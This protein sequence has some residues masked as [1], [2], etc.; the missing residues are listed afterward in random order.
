MPER[1]IDFA[2]LA[3]QALPVHGTQ[4]IQQDARGLSLELDF[5]AATERL[6][7]AGEGAMMARGRAAF[8]STGDTTSAG[9]A[10]WISLPTVGSRLT[11]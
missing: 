10:F 1:E 2:H 9:R 7:T 11:Q 5:G 4:L 8:M 6:A 3:S